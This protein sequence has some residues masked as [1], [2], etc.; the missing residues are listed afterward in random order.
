MTSI[1]VAFMESNN[2]HPLGL[3]IEILIYLIVLEI[4][5]QTGQA[6]IP[7]TL[8]TALNVHLTDFYPA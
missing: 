8:Q 6:S 1:S 7:E 4:I 3:S 2:I 5:I